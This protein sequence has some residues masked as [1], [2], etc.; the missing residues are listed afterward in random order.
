MPN[1]QLV[2][3][4]LKLAY[5]FAKK[6]RQQSDFDDIAQTA[7]IGLIKAARTFDEN[8]KRKFSTY[9]S[10]CIQ[11]EI[12]M[13][14]RKEK[15]QQRLNCVS[16]DEILYDDNGNLL[17]IGDTV[18]DTCGSSNPDSAYENTSEL[19]EA[20]QTI[21]N[22]E[23][24][25]ARIVIQVLSGKPRKEIAAEYGY[26]SV[27]MIGRFVKRA[28]DRIKTGQVPQDKFD[29]D[30]SIERV[31]IINVETNHETIIPLNASLFENILKIL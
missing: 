5:Y 23:S 13:Y 16:L 26:K 2:L 1:E 21:L 3:E 22:L 15:K 17:V 14:F 11:N 20:L 7:M 4:N 12:Y 8:K 18:A 27:S 24:K 10:K 30:V 29:V 28:K 25:H 19:E 31:S 6:F 9:A